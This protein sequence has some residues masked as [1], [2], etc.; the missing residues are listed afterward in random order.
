MLWFC[1]KFWSPLAEVTQFE[2][3]ISHP[4]VL[5]RQQALKLAR[6]GDRSRSLRKGQDP[7][8]RRQVYHSLD[9]S[10]LS[11]QSSFVGHV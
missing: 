4:A 10:L 3:N 2:Q 9:E 7:A 5:Q 6:L 11:S 1:Q 8:S